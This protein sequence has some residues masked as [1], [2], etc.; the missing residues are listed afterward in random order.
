[1]FAAMPVPM[2][3]WSA[4]DN[5]LACPVTD[6]RRPP[7]AQSAGSR[8]AAAGILSPAT[9]T[10]LPPAADSQTAAI[11]AISMSGVL[12]PLSAA[13][14]RRPCVGELQLFPGEL[15]AVMGGN[16]AGKKHAAF[17]IDRALSTTA[18]HYQNRRKRCCGNFQSGKI[19]PDF[20]EHCPRNPRLSSKTVGED[21]AALLKSRG[22]LTNNNKYAWSG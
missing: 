16:G 8:A 9:D 11:T 4:V 6:P 22:S 21:L 15:L 14:R 20:W 5:Q 18:R 19:Y 1:M 7:V 13:G 10:C 12:V 2:R 3:V 17:A